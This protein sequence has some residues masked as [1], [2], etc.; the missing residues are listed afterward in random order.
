[1][2]IDTIKK[3]IDAIEERPKPKW[4]YGFIISETDEIPDETALEREIKRMKSKGYNQIIII[5][6]AKPPNEPKK[7]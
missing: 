7:H 2:S 3:R 1:M 6:P 4:K 5:E